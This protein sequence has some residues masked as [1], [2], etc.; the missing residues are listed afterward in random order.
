[1]K[2]IIC[3]SWHMTMDH[4][5]RRWWS[6]CAPT[7]EYLWLVW[8]PAIPGPHSCMRIHSPSLGDR[9]GVLRMLH[10]WNID[11]RCMAKKCNANEPTLGIKL[12]I[13]ALGICL[14][15]ARLLFISMLIRLPQCPM[16]HAAPLSLLRARRPPW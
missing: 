1:M 3:T 14:N 8:L 4:H 13:V 16:G 6:I 9:Q 7:R 11:H 15:P 5:R 10:P 12:I 2:K